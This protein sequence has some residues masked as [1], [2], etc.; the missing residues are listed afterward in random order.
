MTVP[1]ILDLLT[2]AERST[3]ASN[4]HYTSLEHSVYAKGRTD[5]CR[6]FRQLI[7][8]MSPPA[9]TTTDEGDE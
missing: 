2:M 5:V 1:E 3:H 4:P 8:T 7:A 6:R 9:V